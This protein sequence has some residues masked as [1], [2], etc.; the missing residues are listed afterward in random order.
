L[1]TKRILT[2]D[3]DPSVRRILRQILERAD[4]EVDDAQDGAEALQRIRTRKYDL[5][6][7]D[8]V[9]NPMD[10]VDAVAILR[11]ESTLPIL[12]ISAQLTPQ[13]RSELGQGGVSSFLDKPFT[14][15][16]LLDAVKSTLATEPSGS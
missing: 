1:I 7:M 8:L 10:G 9:M 3:D 15:A 13:N 6:T 2:V 4:Y 14:A 11:N 12:V 5:V 16:E